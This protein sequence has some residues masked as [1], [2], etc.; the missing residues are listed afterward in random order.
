MKSM[1]LTYANHFFWVARVR[2]S[3][4]MMMMMVMSGGVRRDVVG[5]GRGRGQLWRADRTR[6]L[7]AARRGDARGKTRGEEGQEDAR[8]GA[9]ETART[10]LRRHRRL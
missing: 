5:E 7:R 2:L 3:P 1:D 9:I 4:R 6:A 10:Q 8:R